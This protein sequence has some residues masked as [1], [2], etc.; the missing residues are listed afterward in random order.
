MGTGRKGMK[1]LNTNGITFIEA[2]PGSDGS[3]YYGLSFEQGDLYEAEEIWKSGGE[4]RGRDLCLIRYPEGEVY[5]PAQKRPGA[6]P[7]E[8]VYEGGRIFFPEVDFAAKKIRLMAFDCESHETAVFTELPLSAVR[9]CYNLRMH[10][11]P[12]TLTRQGGEDGL[13]EIV[14][15]ERVSFPL[16]KHESFFLRDGDR[17]YFSRWH[18]EGEEET[19]RYWEETVILSLTGEETGCLPGD[20]RLMPDGELWH[21]G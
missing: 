21:I 9:D 15:P 1:E 6:Y 3:W 2:V 4:V 14:W 19:Y 11:R 20:V 16:G 12:H 13:F 5:V 8:A 10:V 17:L 18:E 7:G